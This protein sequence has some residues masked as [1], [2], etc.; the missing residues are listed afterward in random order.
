MVAL[1]I[2]ALGA[3]I[4]SFLA[5]LSEVWAAPISRPEP[6]A[7]RKLMKPQFP[8][9]VIASLSRNALRC[10]RDLLDQDVPKA[11]P[12]GRIAVDVGVASS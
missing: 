1:M 12:A 9:E 3:C 11:G 10:S 5:G 6:E 7:S 8:P 2:L 4:V